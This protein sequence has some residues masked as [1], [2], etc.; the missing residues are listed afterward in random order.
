MQATYASLMSPR[1]VAVDV[2]GILYISDFD[3]QRVYQVTPS[4]ALT[5]LAGTGKSGFSGDGG[6]ATLAQISYP[7]GLVTDM[8]GN[9]YFADSG[10]GRVRRVWYGLI[11]TV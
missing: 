11:T 10:N 8:I 7:A 5:I 3:A 1:N 2:H 4:G 9:I 6:V